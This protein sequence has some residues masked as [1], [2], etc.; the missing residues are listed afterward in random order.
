MSKSGE[1]DPISPQ[2]TAFRPGKPGYP[3]QAGQSTKTRPSRR[4]PLIIGGLALYCFTAYGTYLY[5]SASKTPS[6]PQGA[7][8]PEDVP[9]RY[10]ETAKSFDSEVEL[11][12]KLMGL[13]W[14]RKSLAKRASGHV[15][16][17][18]VGTGR[19]GQYYDLKKCK[20]I[21][22]VDQSPEMIE[23][24]KKKFYGMS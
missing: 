16:E 8:I 3:S 4:G 13:G 5:Y 2:R 10:N 14:R 23:I 17:V 1:Y 15:L 12:E 24:A 21:T 22:F 11:T 18:S 20:S 19:N 6:V 9:D 7:K